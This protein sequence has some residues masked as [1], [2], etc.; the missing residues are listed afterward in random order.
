MLKSHRKQIAEDIGRLQ[1]NLEKIDAKVEYY[2][3]LQ[4]EKDKHE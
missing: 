4:K 2:E 1:A 3:S